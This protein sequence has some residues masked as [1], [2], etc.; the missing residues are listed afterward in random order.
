MRKLLSILL[1][2]SATSAQASIQSFKTDETATLRPVSL[3]GKQ[4]EADST[5]LRTCKPVLLFLRFP[6]GRVM[7]VGIVQSKAAC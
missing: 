7:L 4:P 1:L 3:M 2:L 6:D 5:L